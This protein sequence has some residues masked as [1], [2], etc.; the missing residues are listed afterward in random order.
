M[1]IYHHFYLHI[2][3]HIFWCAIPTFFYISNVVIFLYILSARENSIGLQGKTKIIT[4]VYTTNHLK[5][6]ILLSRIVL[7]HSLYAWSK[8][9]SYYS[10]G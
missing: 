4:D 1:Y 10:L 3:L 6:Q 9:G 7:V 5:L 2:L 8:I